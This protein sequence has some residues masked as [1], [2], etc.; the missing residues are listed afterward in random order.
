MAKVDS[1]RIA[2]L[3]KKLNYTKGKERVDCLNDL[4]REYK[5]QP[6]HRAIPDSYFRRALA[7]SERIGYGEGKAIAMMNIGEYIADYAT[8]RRQD[9]LD[10][11][12]KALDL[13]KSLHKMEI[14]G[15]AYVSLGSS[16]YRLN[17]AK[18]IE[19][20]ET[21]LPYLEKA[22]AKESLSEV[23]FWLL[24]LYYMNGNYEKAFTY[25]EKA[26]Q[27]FKT[28][29]RY[30]QGAG[31]SLKLDLLRYRSVLYAEVGDYGTAMK[32]LQQAKDFIMANK[33]DDYMDD[34]IGILY[35]KMGNY[36]SA[37]HYLN[38][39]YRTNPNSFYARMFVGQ[40]Y[41]ASQQFEKA[42]LVFKDYEDSLQWQMSYPLLRLNLAQ[43]YNNMGS[44]AK[45]LSFAKKGMASANDMDQKLESYSLLSN[46]YQALG[47]F[48]SALYFLRRYSYAKDTISGNKTR[49][50]ERL[51]QYQRDEEGRKKAAAIALL[52]IELLVKLQQIKEQELIKEQKD[53]ELSI[54]GKDNQIIQQQ[55]KEAA[56]LKEQKEAK[57]AL[58]NK[59]N[60]IKE[61][62]LKEGALIRN[63]LL[64][65][66]LLLILAAF[67]IVRT[68]LLKRK[69]EA[70]QRERTENELKLQRLESEKR[71]TELQQ[72][73]TEL[74]MQALR[75]QMNPHFIFN[76]LSS[77]NRYILK[78]E[79]EQASDYLTRF[80]RLIR[81]VL[82]NSQKP[83]IRLEDELDMLRL[84]LDME[85][86][87]FNNVF[88]YNITF[89]N[90]IEPG[91]IFIPPLLLQPF[92]EN[93]IWHG[94]MH[95]KGQGRLDI[96][97]Q[98]DDYFLH[99]TITDNG[100][101]RE[102]A[103]ELKSKSSEQNKSLGLQI[104]N[105]R[106][107]LFNK[108]SQEDSHYQMN[109]VYDDSGNIN[110]TSVEIRIR[111]KELP[112]REKEMTV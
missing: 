111:Y 49:L 24:Q 92:C 93:A 60:R 25:C 98:I 50:I 39:N 2:S 71:H 89:M 30:A 76:C 70:L 56:L 19:L 85:R 59:D 69:N 41:L 72:Q 17:K 7:E 48:D 84:Y 11:L 22:G 6:V 61:Q 13:A 8:Y 35:S 103:A 110:G 79:T 77:I 55:L 73:A 37:F 28:K 78:N 107:A 52:Q 53:A 68:L 40:N 101:G 57:I 109:D 21:A 14:E 62:Q 108:S 67:F 26:L 65:G 36:D 102:K 81:M 88:D 105:N 86:L 91:A 9:G 16:Y 44:Y 51:N 32:V 47:K 43:T 3:Q 1:L 34:A 87:R 100:I 20:W 54:L 90:T 12:Q 31:P 10:T 18:T 99:C 27:A 38:Y 66:L 104:T 33:V 96:A 83:T 75:A 5:Y 58:L 106:L 82:I 95:K 42:F 45:A 64:G 15:L 63:F 46:I 97:L 80:S 29:R 74:E 94:L 4:G 112:E 23:Y